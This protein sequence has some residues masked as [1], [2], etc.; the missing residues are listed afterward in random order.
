MFGLAGAGA[1][2]VLP[3]AGYW[4][5]CLGAGEDISSLLSAGQREQES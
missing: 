2:G 1:E 5:V 3:K 4:D